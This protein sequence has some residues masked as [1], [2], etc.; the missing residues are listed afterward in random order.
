MMVSSI[1]KGLNYD[2][3]TPFLERFQANSD[4]QLSPDYPRNFYDCITLCK[5]TSIYGSFPFRDAETDWHNTIPYVGRASHV[6]GTDLFPLFNSIHLASS[7]YEQTW[8]RTLFIGDAY[9]LP[10]NIRKQRTPF[11]CYTKRGRFC[12]G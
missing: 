8:N 9:L 11:Y 6:L 4:S 12:E 5:I 10:P 2:D 7:E 1:Y 3:E